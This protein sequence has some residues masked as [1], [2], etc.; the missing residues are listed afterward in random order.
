MNQERI[1]KTFKLL[2]QDSNGRT[3]IPLYEAASRL[4]ITK[5]YPHSLIKMFQKKQ[6]QFERFL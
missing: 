1:E 3:L 5:L 6:P 4:D 2:D